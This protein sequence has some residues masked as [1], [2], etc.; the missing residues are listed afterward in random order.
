[1]ERLLARVRQYATLTPIE[2]AS[3]PNWK[4]DDFRAAFQCFS[5]SC[6]AIVH[7][8][9]V[10]RAGQQS[11]P[12]LAEICQKA[13][14]V[15]DRIS[16]SVAR[17][18][19]E[20]NFRAYKIHPTTTDPH[21][22]AGFLTGYYEPIVPGSLQKT[23]AFTEPLLSLPD[24]H[25]KLDAPSESFGL[26]PGLSTALRG[27]NG[28]LTAYPE[29]AAIDRGALAT[30]TRPLVWVR[31]GIEA[32]MIHVQ[33]SARIQLPDGRSLRVKYA[34]RNGHPY[35]SI[36]RVLVRTGRMQAD[37]M[38]LA[39]LKAWVRQAGQARGEGGRELLHRNKSFIFFAAVSDFPED[40]GPIGAAGVH[41]HKL[42]S[43]AVDR[44]I[45][46]YGLP[47]WI[48]ADLPWRT[49]GTLPFRRLM[50]AQDTGSAIIGVARADLFF[51]SGEQSGRLAGGIRHAGQF[52]VLL[53]V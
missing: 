45:W 21:T 38:S 53:P 5:S 42:R 49:A 6:R 40:A 25:A 14:S 4:H 32:F 37:S 36:G 41:L 29:R 23:A 30:R 13:L 26:P 12:L 34:G 10:V 24:H 46:P 3:L 7:S 20:R 27:P 9:P 33:G 47:F 1:M 22:S 31:D 28:N 18:F 2:F 48:D 8:K 17:T 19:F 39:N 50:V 44:N 43:I 15:G 16:N 35:T 11:S 51:G 52:T